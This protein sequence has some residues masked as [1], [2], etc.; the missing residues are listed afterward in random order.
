MNLS[1]VIVS[2]CIKEGITEAFGIPGASCNAFYDELNNAKDKINHI[3]M[4][5][6]E[7]CVH[8]A[9]GY[10]RSS[11]KMALAVCTSGPG[12]TN[13]VTGL[14]TANIDCIP[15]LAITGQA[16]RAQMG[17]D[18]F[19]CVDMVS[20][21]KPIVKHAV[22]LTNPKT[23]V[24]E[25]IEAIKIA[26]TGKP[27]SVLIDFPIDMQ[28]VEVDFDVDSYVPIEVV[29]PKASNLAIKAAMDM[30]KG[31]KNPVILA[32]GG[33]VL[34]N[35]EKELVEFAEIMNI[36]VV[37]TYMAK[38]VI[39]SNHPLYAGMPGIQCGNPIGN[40]TFLE[41]DVVL[42]V[43]NRF[44]DRHTG[45]IGVYKGDRKFIHI[46]VERNEIGKIFTPDLGIVSDAKDALEKLLTSAK[47]IGKQE[48]AAR[49]A[50]IPKERVALERKTCHDCVPINPHRVFGELNK[51]FDAKT[52]FT[53]GCGIT[54]IWSGQMQE[55]DEPRK[56]YP[57][58]GA[59]CLGWDI[60]GAI[61]AMVGNKN[62]DKCVCVMGDFGFTF[63]AQ[64]L[65]TASVNNIP[66]IVVIVNNAYLGLIRQNQKFAYSY[67]H[68][69]A[70]P[71]NHG[72]IDFVTVAKGFNCE[73]ER[74]FNPEDIAGALERAKKS[75]KPY[76]IDI[77]CEQEAH[78]S[79]GPDIASVKEF[80]AE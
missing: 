80:N 55:I 63:H 43:G 37:I 5:H 30:L 62:N 76:V 50:D 45:A 51:A 41:S 11:G 14:Y 1:Q 31:A 46:N 39:S 36:P 52:M 34:A 27:G 67:E 66:L 75:K 65:A 40:K 70:M 44:T 10:Y 24:D 8:A 74:V 58:G 47:E 61:G 15:V 64:E 21:A 17:K 71:E 48:G 16:A 25:F 23:A 72:E 32:G 7:C 4:R 9:D 2:I 73:A 56:Y 22:C 59:G 13:F 77:V 6:E 35:A 53:T 49:V 42:A 28:K 69:V 12:A 54:Q 29:N 79:M 68:G 78:C 3:T 20:I 57:S 26:K 18:A 33:V 19:Q 60:P 38:G